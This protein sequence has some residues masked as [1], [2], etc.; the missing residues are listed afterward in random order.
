[1]KQGVA[2]TPG[3]RFSSGLACGVGVLL[4]KL[5]LATLLGVLS[6]PAPAHAQSSSPQTLSA[7]PD[8]GMCFRDKQAKADWAAQHTCTFC[9]VT[10][11]ELSNVYPGASQTELQ[12]L[13]DEMNGNLML[14][15]LNT[16]KRLTQF[17]AQA[18]EETGST[19]RTSESLVYSARAL[20]L[21]FSYFKNHP[22]EACQYGYVKSSADIKAC[23]SYPKYDSKHSADQA[24][25]ANRAYANRLGNGDVSSGDGWSYRGRGLFQVTGKSNYKDAEGWYNKTFSPQPPIDFVKNPDLLAQ[26][27]FALRTSVAFW[28]QNNL[29]TTADQTDPAKPCTTTNAITRVVNRYTKSYSQRCQHFKDIWNAGTF[30]QVDC[31][32]PQSGGGPFQGQLPGSLFP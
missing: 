26:P 27:K 18:R 3:Q 13:V 30:Q 5:M 24:A 7:C 28:K 1:M 10:T 6:V 25:I 21:T 31:S 4:V 9:A 8:P 11:N 29:D 22:E 16:P 32:L 12:Q 15:G 2:N 23:S 17:F 14:Y 19:L 20:K